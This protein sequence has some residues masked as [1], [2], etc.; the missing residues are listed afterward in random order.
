[1]D[2]V[3]VLP[4]V[5][6]SNGLCVYMKDQGLVAIADLHIGYEAALEE[7][8]V[9]LPRIQTAT[10]EDAL[11]RIVEKYDPEK[12]LIV[13]DLKHEFSRNLGQEW[14]DVRS[15]LSLLCERAK[16]LLVRGNH[17][18]YLKNIASKMDIGIVDRRRV[19]GITFVH[20]HSE[21]A[22]RPLVMAHEHP[23][24]R[25]VD[26]IGAAIRLPCF[27]HF[28]KEDILVMPAFS[29]LAVGTDVTRVEPSD[30]LSPI[31]RNCDISDANVYGCS[32]IGLLN[33]GSIPLL[34]AART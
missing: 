5:W 15:V 31:L 8:G 2:S 16:V 26:R 13:G 24:L 12:V 19:G 32:E 23:S 29:P 28:K 21:C 7:E 25:I 6:I 22:A 30:F 4:G 20:G 9:H 10:M 27:I 11:I 17:D 18:N 33:L 14:S 34:G 3:E 1:M